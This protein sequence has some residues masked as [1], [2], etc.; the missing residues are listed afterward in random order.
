MNLV[1]WL[2]DIAEIW[3]PAY[4]K[5]KSWKLP[6]EINKKFD[7]IWE[8]LPKQIQKAL[9]EL[10]KKIYDKYG[11]EAAIVILG[12]LLGSLKTQIWITR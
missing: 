6:P 12:N 9:W 11:E 10:L 7:E 8:N 1:K 2:N 4:D 3:Q 5:I